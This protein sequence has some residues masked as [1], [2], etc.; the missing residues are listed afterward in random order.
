MFG[1]GK[2]KAK[3]LT[4]SQAFEIFKTTVSEAI[5]EAQRHGVWAATL[6][7]HLEAHANILDASRPWR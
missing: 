5:G 2:A 4:Q 1:I 3:Q 7:Q 6:A